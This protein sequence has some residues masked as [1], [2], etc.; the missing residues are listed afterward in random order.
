VLPAR[1]QQA[2]R[3]LAAKVA[4]LREKLV[5][6]LTQSLDR[7][8]ERSAGRVRAAVAPYERF[9]QGER[10]RLERARAGLAQLGRDLDA[11]VGRAEEFGR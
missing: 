6:A 10:E 1:R 2:R 3:E 5:A 7:E 8:R 11:L 9:V 4:S